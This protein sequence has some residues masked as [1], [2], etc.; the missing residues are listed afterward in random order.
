MSTRTKKSESFCGN[1]IDH[2]EY[3]SD[4]FLSINNCGMSKITEARSESRKARKDNMLIYLTE[5]SGK[6]VINNISMPVSEG[7]I[8]FFASGTPL[9]FFFEKNSQHYWLHFSGCKA[10][11]IISSA[12]ISG[13]GIYKVGI[14]SEIENIFY[15]ISYQIIQS[16]NIHDLFCCSFFIE[17]MAYIKEFLNVN[18]TAVINRTKIYPALLAMSTSYNMPYDLSYYAELCGMSISG[19]KSSFSKIVHVTPLTYLTSIRLERAKILLKEKDLSIS[20]IANQV[21]YQDPLYFSRI[22]KKHIGVSPKD[23]KKN[24]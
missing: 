4:K 1:P 10:E 14:H 9:C 20:Q 22:F 21:G 8:I 13:S 15:K 17:L 23:F 16:N 6:A 24:M 12:G 5:G 7:D 19:F 18:H 11:E 3:Y 2:C